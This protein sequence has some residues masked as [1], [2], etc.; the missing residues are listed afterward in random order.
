MI[1]KDHQSHKRAP[2]RGGGLSMCLALGVFTFN[3]FNNN[4]L[5]REGG[6]NCWKS[7][8]R[9]VGKKGKCYQGKSALALLLSGKKLKKTTKRGESMATG[10]GLGAGR[11]R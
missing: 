2:K 3:K 1:G 9:A 4:A 11:P 8:V 10:K 5:F 7:K 6:R